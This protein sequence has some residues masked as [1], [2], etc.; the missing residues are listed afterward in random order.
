MTAKTKLRSYHITK[1]AGSDNDGRN[2]LKTVIAQRAGRRKTNSTGLM[3]QQCMRT[4]RLHMP[5]SMHTSG[6]IQMNVA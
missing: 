1:T 2:R 4:K 3:H 5:R 6:C